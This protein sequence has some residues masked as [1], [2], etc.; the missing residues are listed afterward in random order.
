MLVKEFLNAMQGCAMGEKY[1]VRSFVISRY[2]RMV[3][4]DFLNCKNYRYEGMEYFEEDN[5]NYEKIMN[6]K[7]VAVKEI[8][9]TNN[10]S[11]YDNFV[12][13]INI[14]IMMN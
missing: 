9:L 10:S 12:S 6:S 2:T 11:P 1:N 7:V 4:C 3:F 13:T 5:E 8:L 14:V